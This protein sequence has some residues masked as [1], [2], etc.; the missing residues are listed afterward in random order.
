MSGHYELMNCTAVLLGEIA[1][2]DMTPDDVASS[3]RLAIQSSET[4]NWREVNAAIIARWGIRKLEKI[5]IK[6]RP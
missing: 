6:A 1:N 5:K 4:T 3:Y 2:P